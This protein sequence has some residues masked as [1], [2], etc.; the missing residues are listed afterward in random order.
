MPVDQVNAQYLNMFVNQTRPKIVAAE[1]WAK[2]LNDVAQADPDMDEEIE[3]A[4]AA[5]YEA[6]KAARER[7][8]AIALRLGWKF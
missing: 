7:C 6:A 2:R 8:D 4:T 1:A 3:A 5:M